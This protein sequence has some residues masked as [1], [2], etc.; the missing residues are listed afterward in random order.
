MDI[1]FIIRLKK[2]L[3]VLFF[4]GVAVCGLYPVKNQP[5]N[6][7]IDSDIGRKAFFLSAEE[8]ECLTSW[9]TDPKA[10]PVAPPSE[11]E[12][13][14]TPEGFSVDMAGIGNA[15]INEIRISRRLKSICVEK[16]TSGMLPGYT[17]VEAD[18]II[19]N[20]NACEMFKTD[21][22]SAMLERLFA[23]EILLA[24]TLFVRILLN[25]I[26]E[27]RIEGST[28]NHG[29]VYEI[30]KFLKELTGYWEYMN[31][32]AK[33]D[34]KAEVANSYLNRL[35]WLLE[36]FFNM[37][38]YVI[39]FGRFLGNSI[40]NYATFIYSSLLM[41]NYFSKTINYS[42]KSIRGN[43]GIVSNIYVPKHV[44]LITNMILDFYKL[45][46][47]FTVLVPML[48]IFHIKIG[49]AVFWVLAA[50]AVMILFSFGVGMVLMH[51]GVYIDDLSYAV[52][53][54]LQMLMFLSG[55]FYDVITGLQHPLNTIMLSVNPASMFI[56]TMR[57]ALLYNRVA[58]VP[59]VLLWIVLSLLIGYIGLHIVYKNEN[60]YVKSV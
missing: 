15:R 41:W 10:A 31:Y 3:I 24:M 57:N 52:G 18:R 22:Q 43:M 53:I 16:I 46:F 9:V 35:W 40:E 44:L 12:E 58:N 42:V 39:V 36:P 28:G 17:V 23:A 34:L 55:P 14:I 6:I 27:T 51:Y 5:L 21:S 33:A 38:V 25:A 29:P 56:D 13:H 26:A 47:S 20:V 8:A 11:I 60:A 49:F 19:F 37:L 48:F 30:K 45:L 59:L 50:Y 1:R 54:L 2:A 32:A 7:T 4:I